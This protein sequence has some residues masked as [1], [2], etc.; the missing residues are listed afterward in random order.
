MEEERDSHFALFRAEVALGNGGKAT[1]WGYCDVGEAGNHIHDAES[2][3]IERA[4]CHLG[5]SYMADAQVGIR[6]VD[7]LEQ[8]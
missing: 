5:L 3:A 4:I 6:A 7:E 2:L 1:G 8:P